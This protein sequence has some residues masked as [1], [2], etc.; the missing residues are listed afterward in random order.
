MIKRKQDR[1]KLFT[2]Q[3]YRLI[4]QNRIK[5]EMVI[6]DIQQIKRF[7]Y[8]KLKTIERKAIIWMKLIELILKQVNITITKG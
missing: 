1:E 3:Y 5:I 6:H 4:I 7:N 2:I 8:L